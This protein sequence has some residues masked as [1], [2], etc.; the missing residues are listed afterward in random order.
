MS[1]DLATYFRSWFEDV[2]NQGRREVIRERFR[3]GSPA[4]GLGEA[5]V[6]VSGPDEFEPFYDTIRGAFPDIKIQV[7][8]TIV[9][10]DKVAGRWS[11]VATHRGP[12]LGVAPTNRRVQFS[13]MSI[14]QVQDGKIVASWNNWDQ[15]AMLEQIA[16]RAQGESIH[17]LKP[18]A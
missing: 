11:A 18:K 8:D 14:I 5:G 10:G 9:Q 6:T 15:A 3:A 12:Q 16:P 13:G 2:W 7:H 17:F 1:T 4:E